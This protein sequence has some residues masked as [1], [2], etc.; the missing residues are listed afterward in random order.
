VDGVVFKTHDEKGYYLWSRTVKK[1]LGFTSEHLSRIFSEKWTDIITGKMDL[2]LH[3]D[4]L[5]K[6]KLFQDLAISP[7]Q[8]IDYW[9]RPDYHINLDIL[10]LV[11]SLKIPCYLGTNQEA[12]RTA[13]IMNAVG[14]YFKQCF[15][16]YKIG[17][18]KPE[19][20]FFRHIEKTLSLL[21]SQVLLI[22]DTKDNIEGAKQWGWHVYHYQ[23]DLKALQSFLSKRIHG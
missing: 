5:F 22:D 3:L 21:P 9:L 13:C 6:E 15:A 1:D 2:K 23:N 19:E 4:V 16:S 10:Q 20:G 18:M 7:D 14:S 12:V 11:K 8:F 17:S